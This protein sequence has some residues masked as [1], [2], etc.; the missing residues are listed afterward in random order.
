V[1]GLRPLLIERNVRRDEPRGVESDVVE[2]FAED[3]RV[4]L[5]GL[6]ET[7]D[8]RSGKISPTSSERRYSM[9][10]RRRGLVGRAMRLA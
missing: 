2:R 1:N 7:S 4:L 8:P 5:R 10:T 9:S 3:L 6:V